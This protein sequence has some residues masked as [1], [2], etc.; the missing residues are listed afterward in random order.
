MSKSTSIKFYFKH[1]K[2]FRTFDCKTRYVLHAENV[3]SIYDEKQAIQR[4]FDA[5]DY[6]F[7][8]S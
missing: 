1:F 7:T 6:T 3:A 2:V 5:F 4:C 8:K